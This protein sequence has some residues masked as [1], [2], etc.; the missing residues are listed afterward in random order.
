[1]VRFKNRFL[2]VEVTFH[3][4]VGLHG[5]ELTSRAFDAAL[6]KSVQR[7]FGDFGTAATQ[8]S[9]ATRW[10][11][12][13]TGLAIVRVGA[14]HAD[15]VTGAPLAVRFGRRREFSTGVRGDVYRRSMQLLRRRLRGRPEGGSESAGGSGRGK[16][17]MGP[18]GGT[19]PAGQRDAAL[20]DSAGARLGLA[21]AR[22]G[23]AAA[24]ARARARARPG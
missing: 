17:D 24:H 20:A 15:M 22:R 3:E 19:S 6:R 4:D 7:N 9:L 21:R 23:R 1:M 5:S 2:V 10:C 12:T 18:G 16:A 14:A 8:A 13:R 11:E